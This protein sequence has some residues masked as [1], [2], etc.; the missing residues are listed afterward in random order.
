[1]TER[2]TAWF[3]LC[4]TE[5]IGS[6]ALDALLSS[7]RGDALAILRADETALR[8]VRGIGQVLSAR[9]RAIDLA[10]VAR[11]LDA[12]RAHD[13]H[14]LPREHLA[15][16]RRLHALPDPPA[17]LFV[18]GARDLLALFRPPT[19]GVVGTRT[20]S[21]AG[22]AEAARI[23]RERARDGAI[24]V[25]GLARGIDTLA[26]RAALN[27]NRLTA[28]VLGGGFFHLYPP[29]NAALAR[30]MIEMG[31]ALLSETPPD[32]PVSRERLVIRNRLIAALSDR[33]VMVESEA[34]GGAM[35]AVRYARQIG[36][37]VQTLNLPASGNQALLAAGCET[38]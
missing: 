38:A 31:G 16:P 28:A 12:W 30:Q 32:M 6:S 2:E 3:A 20:P 4:L 26:H 14:L 29:E 24:V 36:R 27:A 7:F 37:V 23:A 1:M 22:A 15:Y 34:D 25:S 21:E 35:H 18:R 9:I 8:R 11:R 10:S 19:S 13:I 33:L 5:G 17:L